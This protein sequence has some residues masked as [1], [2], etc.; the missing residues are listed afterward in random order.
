MP[1]TSTRV[2]TRLL[3]G[4]LAAAALLLLAAP[5]GASEAPV[6]SRLG[7]GVA[8]VLEA[9]E[10]LRAE[11]AAPEPAP[12]PVAPDAAV[13]P[14]AT[15]GAPATPAAPPAPPAAPRCP[16]AVPADAGLGTQVAEIFACRLTEAG[17][18]PA[19]VRRSTAEALVVAGCESEWDASAV[20]FEGRY[21]AS[22]HP[23]GNRYTAAG[24]FQLIRRVADRWV[25]GGYAAVLD[26]RA[27][28]D[29][30]AR[31]HVHTRAA[32]FRGWED[33]A[34]AAASDGFR[35]TSVL[36]GWPGGPAEL[37]AWAWELADAAVA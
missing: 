13:P 11:A 17:Y 18:A 25:E 2:R 32:G 29:A 4:A 19:E 3:L 22:P 36:P 35:A 34:C 27:N 21:A 24:V 28:I 10:A 26:P 33:W 5:A 12:S 16:D 20:V 23:N 14:A 8:A 15:P 1:S 37:P 6:L 9:I 7:S 30:A 31:L